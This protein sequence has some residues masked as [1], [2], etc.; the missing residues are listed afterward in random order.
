[1]RLSRILTALLVSSTIAAHAASISLNFSENDGNQSWLNETDLIGPLGTA[2]GAFNT[3][4]NPTGAAGLPVR[5][6][7]LGSGAI[8]NL[9]DDSGAPTGVNVVWNSSTAWFN[10][11]GVADNASRLAVG[12]LDDGD[13]GGQGATVTLSNLSYSLYNV[14]LLLGSDQSGD[15]YTSQDFTV[16]GN[17][18]MGGTFSAFSNW[19]AGSANGTWTEADGTNPGN[20]IVARNQSGSTLDIAGAIRNGVERGSLVGVIV[21]EVPEPAVPTLLGAL[22]FLF[23]LRRRQ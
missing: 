1:M 10:G 20:Y 9:V 17:P 13:T 16:N 5:T 12:Y 23:L 22:A 18:V 19:G 4:N 7:T 14:Y 11:S 15:V 21:E 6:G 3:S 2:T 8:D